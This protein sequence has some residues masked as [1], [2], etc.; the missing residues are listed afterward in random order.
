ML[1]KLICL[2]A[3]LLVCLPLPLLSGASAQEE[4]ALWAPEPKAV[5][6]FSGQVIRSY[7]SDTLQYTVEKFKVDGVV[8]YLSKIW[9]Q[10][11]ARQIHKET[12]AWKKNIQ[13]PIIMAR[14]VKDAALVIN[15]S[16]YVSPVYPWIPENYPG[17]SADYY[18]TPLGSLTVTGGEVFRNLEGVPYSGLTLEEDGLHMYTGAENAD[19]LARAPRETW[20]F[21]VQCPMMRN[22]QDILPEDWPFADRE[23]VRTVISRVNQNNYLILSVSKRGGRGLSLRRVNTFFQKYFD[24]EWVYDLDGGPSS[25]LICRAKGRKSLVT[26]MGGEAR[27]ADIMAFTELPEP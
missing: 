22:N 12:A 8:C 13:R 2:L 20:S 24:T 26:V 5:Y 14:R 10:D 16:G 19:V 11:P 4:E 21:Y 7:D 15:G 17:T 25:A 9:V 3:C 6:D 23:A 1:R 27:D 18:Y